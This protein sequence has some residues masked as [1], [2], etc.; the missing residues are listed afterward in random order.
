MLCN[1][2]KLC[3]SKNIAK[4]N[5]NSSNHLF[6]IVRWVISTAVASLSGILKCK[7]VLY[8]YEGWHLCVD[9]IEQLIA[10][11]PDKMF[12]FS[13]ICRYFKNSTGSLPILNQPV[14]TIPLGSWVPKIGDP[15]GRPLAMLRPNAPLSSARL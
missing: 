5:F 13:G 12:T 1:S 4:C 11:Y 9:A 10:R 14:C 7:F 2:Y 8:L 15:N 6:V 3:D